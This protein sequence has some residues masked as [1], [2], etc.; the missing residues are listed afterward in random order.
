MTHI[1]L[2][3]AAMIA[4]AP[5]FAQG[6]ASAP[7]T[8]PVAPT[9]A[10]AHPVA[11]TPESSRLDINTASIEQLAAVKGLTRTYAEAI[12]KARPF[13]SVDDLST[14]KILPADVFAHVK[15]ALTVRK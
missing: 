14:G 8:K 10:P 9:M 12:M 4:A 3:A 13:K 7:V 11:M 2:F 5:A 6:A 1:A 15:D